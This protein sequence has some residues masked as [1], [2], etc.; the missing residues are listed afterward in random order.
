[1]E[2]LIVIVLLAMV[3]GGV[4]ILT[5]IGIKH[6]QHVLKHKETVM[7]IKHGYPLEGGEEKQLL[8]PEG[9]KVK[10]VGYIDMTRDSESTHSN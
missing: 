4:I 10:D 2:W 9:G 8:P 1:M 3:I 5:K 7:R 6:H